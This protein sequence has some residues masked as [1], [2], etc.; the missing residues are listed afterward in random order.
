MLLLG[1]VVAVAGLLGTVGFVAMKGGDGG[2]A[3]TLVHVAQRGPFVHE[4]VERG[5][6][7]SSRNVEIRCEV[8][9]R[10]STGTAILEVVPEGTEVEVGDLLVRLDSSALELERVQQQIIVATAEAAMI[11]AR[12]LFEAAEIAR[13][14]Y[15]N[16]TYQQERQTIEQEVFAAEETLRRAQRYAEYSQELAAKGYVTQ[17]QLE[18]DLFEVEKSDKALEAANTKLMVLDEYTK[19]KMLKDLDSQIATTR[20]QW[21]AQESTYQLELNK[22]NEIERQIAA[23]TIVAPQAGQVVYANEEDRR[24]DSEFIVQPGALVREQQVLIRLPDPQ[25]MQVEA[26]VNEARITLIKVDMPVKIRLDAF[27]DQQLQGK[28]VK[29]NK[30][31]ESGGWWSS[32]VKEY[33]SFVEI[34]SPPA[35][36]RTGLTAEVRIEV[37]RLPDELQV[38]VQ[39]VYEHGGTLYCMVQKGED[40][41][42]R[43]ILRGSSNDKFVVVTQ[44]LKEGETVALNPDA[45][46]NRVNLPKLPP[47]PPLKG[48]EAEGGAEA[49]RTADI[50]PDGPPV[51]GPSGTRPPAGPDGPP[52]GIGQMVSGILERLDRNSN[53][54]IDSD[55]IE[56]PQAE[57]LREA[58]R[59]GDGAIDRGELMSAM[60]QMRAAMGGGAPPADSAAGG[61]GS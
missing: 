15:L 12:N 42:A 44:G 48:T 16:G 21:K 8:E 6:L 2:Q 5:E 56:G 51:D 19:P 55:E 23:C 58:D 60:A 7:E 39:A 41:E 22:L 54:R 59:N 36:L 46:L 13:T 27:P 38:P 1:G 17:L 52:G 20:A 43:Q 26:L 53:G 47:V 34:N 11:Q 61:E 29:V 40:W 49:S 30:Y 24:G 32:Q 25:H 3:T 57:R 35:N 33:A 28:V 50:P 31:P 18:G 10:N 14:Q 9:S 4:V 45:V 37:E